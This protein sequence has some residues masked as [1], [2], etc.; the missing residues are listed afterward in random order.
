MNKNDLRNN[1]IVFCHERL[2]L[3]TGYD[4]DFIRLARYVH[5]T[6]LIYLAFR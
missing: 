6:V 1:K 4:G 5:D 2:K 3:F